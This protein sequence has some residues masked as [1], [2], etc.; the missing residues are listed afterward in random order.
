M[1]RVDIAW[2]WRY[3]MKLLSC[4][5]YDICQMAL[6]R[7]PGRVLFIYH[8]IIILFVV[9]QNQFANAVPPRLSQNKN[10]YMHFHAT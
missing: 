7:I 2:S 8:L 10:K 5:K 1:L 6:D 3:F 9:D 4:W